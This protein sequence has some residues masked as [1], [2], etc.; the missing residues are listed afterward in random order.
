MQGLS[1]VSQGQASA[2][3]SWR[4]GSRG[5]VDTVPHDGR[6]PLAISFSGALPDG[7]WN[8]LHL[9]SVTACVSVWCIP[10][11]S[12]QS[13]TCV[14]CTTQH[15]AQSTLGFWLLNYRQVAPTVST[16]PKDLMETRQ[17][18]WIRRASDG[19]FLPLCKKFRARLCI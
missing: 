7:T 2:E 16:G 12:S 4:D 14:G 9:V 17:L 3:V 8:V 5:S 13:H 6:H 11:S 18:K 19:P 15:T 10:P 1:R